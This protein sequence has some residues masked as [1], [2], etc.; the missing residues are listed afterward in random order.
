MQYV[1]P[2]FNSSTGHVRAKACWVA[3]YYA[4]AD[5]N[6]HGVFRQL[7]QA[8]VRAL[9]DS[10]LPVR[11]DALVALR[12]FVEELDDVNQLKGIV[13][14]VLTELF[15]LLHE[16]D[17]EDVVYTLEAIVEKFGE[18]ISP[19]ALQLLDQLVSAFW[20]L[21]QS[22]EQ[23]ESEGEMGAL[24]SVGCLRA[25]STIMD[26]VSSVKTLFPEMEKRIFPLFQHMLNEQGQDIYEELLE[27]L[28]YL[29]YYS[30]RISDQL[31]S[32][33]EPLIQ[34]GCTW[35]NRYLE[36]IIIPLDNYVTRGTETFLQSEHPNCV[37]QAFQLAQR[38]LQNDEL[39]ADEMLPGA[40]IL[41]AIMQSCQGRI[42]HWIEAYITLALDTLHHAQSKKLKTALVLVVA[43]AVL[44]NPVLTMQ[45]LHRTGR[46]Q[47]AFG[48]WSTFL[49]ETNESGKRKYFKRETDKK[50]NGLALLALLRMPREATPQE[51]EGSVGSVFGMAVSMLQDYKQQSEERE[52]EEQNQ[53]YFVDE[54]D[55]ADELNDLEDVDEDEEQEEEG[56]A[57]GSRTDDGA[58][59]AQKDLASA[60][61]LRS[62]AAK[63][64]FDAADDD[65]DSE[66]DILEDLDDEEDVETP[67]DKVNAFMLLKQTVDQLAH[68]D[69]DRL[70]RM[71]SGVSAEQAS[72]AD[73]LYQHA[74]QQEQQEEQQQ[75]TSS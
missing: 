24:A 10:E 31:W 62:S 47:E 58:S 13:E 38:T 55:F 56:Q 46:L 32:L 70:N 53:D 51:V 71:R 43:N 11:V 66:D 49:M 23:E 29:T 12:P 2:Y 35:A 22:E 73:A 65:A 60:L 17:N 25:M 61:G 72:A 27:L 7:F 67:V 3:G 4:N 68:S 40:K 16:V 6:D 44:Y 26:S 45:I 54:D 74:A 1:L 59:K 28:A 18:E 14:E 15:K 8:V 36:T 50:V 34:Q 48:T 20:K 39:D 37:S 41:N 52:A 69:T 9:S 19:Y 30:P 5:F 21:I 64:L 75:S 42:D 57:D 63:E 33:W